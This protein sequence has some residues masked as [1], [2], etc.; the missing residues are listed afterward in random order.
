MQFQFY[1]A[2]CELAGHDGP[3]NEC[4]FYGSEEAGKR[5]EQMLAMGSSRPWPDALEKLTGT[6]EMDASAII[7][8]FQPLMGWLEEQNEG[9]TCGW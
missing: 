8:Y 5:L 9:K 4:S 1:K 6:R 2:M 7:D 3:L